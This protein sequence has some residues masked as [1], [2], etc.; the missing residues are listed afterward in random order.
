M[1]KPVITVRI[2]GLTIKEICN[3]LDGREFGD[4][5]C[6]VRAA[7]HGDLFE[8]RNKLLEHIGYN[9]N[10]CCDNCGVE[11]SERCTNE[12]AFVMQEGYC[13]KWKP[14]NA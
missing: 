4:D 10:M 5:E 7:S 13:G 12:A 9:P 14:K 11:P 2:E 3:R 8:E 6:V 1:K